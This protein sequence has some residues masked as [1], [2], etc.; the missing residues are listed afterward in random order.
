MGAD[1]LLLAYARSGWDG[2][3]WA[4]RLDPLGKRSRRIVALAGLAFRSG[5]EG[6]RFRTP[7]GIIWPRCVMN[8]NGDVAGVRV[9]L[10]PAGGQ[11]SG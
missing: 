4:R 6:K 1:K 5:F 3:H 9:T 10:L 7:R 11:R 8:D 2:I